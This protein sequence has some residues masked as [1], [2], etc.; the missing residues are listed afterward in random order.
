MPVDN[1]KN[2]WQSAKAIYR[3]FSKDRNS[4]FKLLAF[5]LFS[6]VFFGALTYKIILVPNGPYQEYSAHIGFAVRMSDEGRIVSPH[7]LFQ[8]LTIIHHHLFE[9]FNPPTYKINNFWDRFTYYDWGISAFAVM[10]EIYIGI[11]LLL[12]GYLKRRFNDGVKNFDNAAYFIAFG[13]SICAPIFLLAPIDGKYYLGYLTPSTIYMLPTQVLLKLPSLA[14]FL[15]TPLMFAR[16]RNGGKV[17]LALAV[18][19]LISGLSKPSWLLIMLPALGIIALVKFIKK[20]PINWRSLGATLGAGVG[21][22]SWQYY[23]KF[24]DASAPVYQSGIILTAPF[25]VWRHHSDFILIKM[26]LS[27]AF[28]LYVTAAYLEKAKCDFYVKYSWLLFFIGLIYS[29]FLGE[30][31]KFKF[32]GN[33]IWCGEIACFVLFV[34]TASLFF[35]AYLNDRQAERTKSAIGLSLFGAH[36]ICGLI[37]YFRSFDHIFL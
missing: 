22:L 30:S 26:V 14:L 11:E 18:F 7:F 32:A 24:V 20:Y 12:A 25:E 35:S 2:E 31:G 8:L 16:A 9:I 21:A 5:V 34:A 33:F 4:L 3:H 6:A 36:V 19:V 1:T 29:G 15:M 23:F 27:I 28:P 10:L 37:Y 17:A 13:I